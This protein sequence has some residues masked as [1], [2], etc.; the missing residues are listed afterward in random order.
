MISSHALSKEIFQD[1]AGVPLVRVIN[2]RWK[3]TIQEMY[4]FYI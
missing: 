4:Y 2:V 1:V 3:Q